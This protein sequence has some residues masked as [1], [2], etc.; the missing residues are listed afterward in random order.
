M[1]TSTVTES[2]STTDSLAV[3]LQLYKAMFTAAEVDRLEQQYTRSGEAFF[4]VA[5]RGHE[6][7][8]ALNPHLIQADYLNCHYRSKALMLARG[9]STRDMFAGFFAVDDSHSRGRQMSAHLSSP[10]HHITSIVG[11]VG[12]NALQA[13]GIATEIKGNSDKP[14]SVCC[15]GEGTTQ[16][17]EVLEALHEASREQLPVLFVVE[18]N[19]WAI[20][21]PTNGRTFYTLGGSDAT[22]Y[23]GIPI[24]YVDGLDALA[25]Y[26]T[27]G[28]AAGVVR[29]QRR[30]E[31]VIMRTRR[32]SD[33]TNADDQSVYRS[34]DDIQAELTNHCPVAHLGRTLIGKGFD[35]L[36][37]LQAEIT[38]SVEN[39]ALEALAGGTPETTTE[40]ALPLHPHLADPHNEYRGND[41]GDRLTMIDAMRTVLENQ[42]ASNPKVSLYGQ[43]IEDPKGD[44]FGLTRGLSTRFSEQVKNSPLSESTIVGSAV[45]RAMAGG[46]PVALLQFADFMPLAFNQICSEISTMYWRTDGGWQC[47]VIIMAPCGGYR[48]GLGHFHA[49][50]FESIAAH[51]PGIDVMM[52]SNAADAAG[53]LNAAF[54]S[55]RPTIFFYPKACLNDRNQTTSSD[56]DKQL[57]TIGHSRVARQGRDLTMVAW[58][59]TV[60]RAMDAASI[61]EEEGKS[62][63][64][65]DL[66]SIAPWDKAGVIK[67]VEKTGRL[68]VIHEDAHTCGMGGEIVATVAEAINESID[69]RRLTKPD[70]HIPCNF[71]NQLDIMPS[72]KATVELAADMLDMSV[73][74]AEQAGSTDNL[75]LIEAIGASP[76][77]ES[78]TIN[79]WHVGAGDTVNKGDL[80]VEYEADKAATELLS[81][82]SGTVD[83]ILAEEDDSVKVGAPILKL[84]VDDPDFAK[85][86]PLT[87][88][89]LT[90]PS[91]VHHAHHRAMNEKLVHSKLKVGIKTIARAVGSATASNEDVLAPFADKSAEDIIKGTGIESRPRAAEGETAVSLAAQ[92]CEQ[93]LDTEGLTLG[94]ID[95]I[96]C[97]TGTPELI[98][99]STACQ[100]MAAVDA[101]AECAAYDINAACS[102]YI[103][104][105]QNAWD[106]L[107]ANPKARVIVI[108]TELLSPIL[109][110]D[111]YTTAILFGD[112]ATA[113][114]VCGESLMSGCGY[115][116]QRPLLSAQGEAGSILTV[117]HKDSSERIGMDGTKV[118][119]LGVRK[120]SQSLKRVLDDAEIGLDDLDLIVPHQA[121]Q[122]IISAIIKKVGI[123]EEKVFSNIRH[124]GNTSSNTIPLALADVI[125]AGDHPGKVALTAFGGG[126]TYGAC[127]LDRID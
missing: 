38:T 35:E 93:L 74:W 85:G 90:E 89:I 69:C 100:V 60:E 49:Q 10:Q 113:T 57:V 50:T 45:G 65:I 88:E 86:K 56:I 126:F 92:A 28:E 18:D 25:C 121:N 63:E 75:A 77:D 70:T 67:S 119:S 62:V 96:I 1:A 116:L 68:L 79:E 16:Q 61:L 36:E 20:S 102:G 94:D 66:R 32:L 11:P 52:P 111:D 110:T 112:A 26:E 109:D 53:M 43:D 48:A 12:N 7:V 55:D 15:L 33:H 2:S 19:Q 14:I 34:A 125:D 123:P 91:F 59:N 46:K 24:H 103:Y 17:G 3:P 97:A 98:T 22:E 122:R 118:F 42:L 21:T 83:S 23:C 37:A 72:V 104:A 27:F 115:Q 108:T 106:Y 127:L 87:R 120:M 4:H 78:V 73:S 95:T 51:L 5:G 13:V 29:S 80:L 99:P 47:P 54:Q 39:A 31:I 58:G 6:S 64:V 30:P 82:Y 107:Q 117:P 81:P 44:V 124:Y 76:S 114:L 71:A 105:L 41:E 101:N 84:A 8:A 40:T 9:M